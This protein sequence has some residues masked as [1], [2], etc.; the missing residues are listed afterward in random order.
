M[1]SE[2]VVA[3]LEV[4]Y[5]HLHTEVHVTWTRSGMNYQGKGRI[6]ALHPREATIE[7][8]HSVGHNSEYKRGDRIQAPRYAYRLL[9]S[10]SCS[11]R[12][13]TEKPFI[14]KDFL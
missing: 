3:Q 13:I 9:G 4:Q 10:S 6:V 7:L 11:V 1:S 14:H 8:L 12:K 2:T 5:L